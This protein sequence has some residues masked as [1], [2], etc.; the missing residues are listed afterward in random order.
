LLGEEEKMAEPSFKELEHAGWSQR[1][2]AYDTWFSHITSQAH[3]PLLDALGKPLG[4]ARLLD[5]CTGT[6][7]LAAA[8]A[9]RGALAEG[10]DF[11][12]EMVERARANHPTVRFREGDAEQL[13]YDDRSFDH[14]LCAFGHLHLPNADQAIAEALRVLKPGGRYAFAVWR[15]HPDGYFPSVIDAIGRYGKTDVG[16]PPSPPFF[17]F[18]DPQEAERVLRGAGFVDVQTRTIDLIWEPTRTEDLV[19]WIYKCGVRT[20]MMLERQTPEARDS[21][22]TAIMQSGEA[23]RRN[24]TLRVSFPASIAS[25]RRP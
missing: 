21:I 1:A 13:P 11:S 22:H 2:G 10:L 25:A 4:G 7:Y 3:E 5:V 18:G 17:R 9:K 12:R 20:T 19:E 23:R 8:A 6:G 16:L 14:V 15:A 24:G